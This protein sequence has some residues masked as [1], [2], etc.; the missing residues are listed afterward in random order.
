MQDGL[1]LWTEE[2][3]ERTG[4]PNPKCL[5]YRNT[6]WMGRASTKDVTGQ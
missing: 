2:R 6:P 3:C 1:A 4:M 5:M